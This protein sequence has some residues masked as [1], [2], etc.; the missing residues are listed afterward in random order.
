MFRICIIDDDKIHTEK[1]KEILNSILINK[2][3]EFVIEEYNTINDVK[4]II[5][6][7]QFNYHCRLLT[8]EIVSSLFCQAKLKMS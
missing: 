6:S 4:Q 8:N 1:T 5:D 7:N 3:Q 2:Q